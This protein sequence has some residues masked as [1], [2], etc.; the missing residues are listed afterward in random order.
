MADCQCLTLKKSL[1]PHLSSIPLKP[2]ASNTNHAAG[3]THF[4]LIVLSDEEVH[5]GA[6]K[7]TPSYVMSHCFL[8][9]WP[10]SSHHLTISSSASSHHLSPRLISLSLS[11][12]LLPQHCPSLVSLDL[13][14]SS[15]SDASLHLLSL[16]ATRL[17]SLSLKACRKVRPHL[18]L[19]QGMQEGEEL[20]QAFCSP[21]CTC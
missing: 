1:T 12:T 17:T 13:S 21:Q 9:P 2:F 4:H 6:V 3:N 18:S 15:I 10:A 14:S 7:V 19:A 8:P 20:Q 16:H 11:P 5:Y